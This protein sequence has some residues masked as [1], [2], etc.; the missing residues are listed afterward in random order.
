MKGALLA[1]AALHA[2][3]VGL[4]LAAGG[5]GQAR[6]PRAGVIEVVLHD[7]AAGEGS[8]VA[9]ATTSPSPG[10]PSAE[11]APPGGTGAARR[12]AAPR[13]RATP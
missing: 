2:A 3:V 13:A 1:S 7:P 11:A 9:A 8:R 6:L 4:A 10:R 12:A 5:G